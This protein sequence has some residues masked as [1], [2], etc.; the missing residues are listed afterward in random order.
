MT[1]AS[2]RRRRGGGATKSRRAAPTPRQ[3]YCIGNLRLILVVV[4]VVVV[5]SVQRRKD[6]RHLWYCRGA[7]PRA[8]ARRRDT[9]LHGIADMTCANSKRLPWAATCRDINDDDNNNNNNRHT[10]D[11]NNNNNKHII[12]IIMNTFRVII[13]MI[14]IL[15]VS[16]KGALPSPLSD[17]L[18]PKHV[19]V[20]DNICMYTYIYIY[21]YIHTYIH[22]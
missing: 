10:N 13:V 16:R 20:H 21:I 3:G 12:T 8:S 1:A 18:C 9:V 4:V 19:F 6:C 22:T 11:N 5:S 15:E 2:A 7:R 17:R 14:L